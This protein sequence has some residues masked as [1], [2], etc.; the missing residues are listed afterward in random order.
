[1][2]DNDGI[3]V[4]IDEDGVCRRYKEPYATIECPTEEDYKRFKDIIDSIIPKPKEEWNEEEGLCLWW[5]FP[6]NT[7]PYVGTPLDKDFPSNVTHFTKIEQPLFSK[8]K[9]SSVK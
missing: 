8:V 3:L 1:M 2:N 4:S 7:Q 5:E 9:G 6:V